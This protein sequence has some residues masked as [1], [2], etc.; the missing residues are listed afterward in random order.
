MA[1]ASIARRSEQ[2]PQNVLRSSAVT[3]GPSLVMLLWIAGGS[4]AA[5][6]V[7]L[8]PQAW[9]S[10]GWRV[11]AATGL[12]GLISLPALRVWYLRWGATDGEVG[13]G[14]PGD[15]LIARPVADMT[16]AVTV[17]ASPAAVWSWL[18]QL[19]QGRGGLF[20][21]D[22]LE[23]LAG[24]D[25]HTLD[26]IV[27]E[28]QTIEV[29]ELIALGP[30]PNNGLL[31]SDVQRERALVL[32]RCDGDHGGPVNQAGSSYVD[33]SWAFVLIPVDANTTR[34]VSRFRLA[35][36]PRILVALAY[37]LLMEFP[38]FV[39]ERKMLLGIAR[40]AERTARA[41]AR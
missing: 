28:L 21:Y 6:A 15:E 18:V 2:R 4:L 40:R 37:A 29:G 31:V 16:R 39:M 25:I 19:G 38:H 13:G 7:T 36:K 27:P 33:L 3:M 32:R 8:A 10:F 35:A 14:L 12:F 26:R 20:S 1:H 23:N 5:C 24:L 22:W 11:F 9:A 34:L 30:G 41:S 17:H